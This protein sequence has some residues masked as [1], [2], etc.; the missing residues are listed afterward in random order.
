MIQYTLEV[1]SDIGISGGFLEAN[2]VVPCAGH[3]VISL[4]ATHEEANT[5]IILH[6]IMQCH[7]ELYSMLYINSMIVQVGNVVGGNVGH[8]THPPPS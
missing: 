2:R 4:C 1:G 5:P 7:T 3:D 6:A 8:D